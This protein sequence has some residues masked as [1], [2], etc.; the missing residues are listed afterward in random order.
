MAEHMDDPLLPESH[1]H[2]GHVPGTDDEGGC[3][4]VPITAEERAQLRKVVFT[5]RMDHRW[6][7]LNRHGTYNPGRND[8]ANNRSSIVRRRQRTHVA[9]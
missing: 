9:S 3:A 7:Y 5:Q 1:V 8:S 6:V 2:E 4:V